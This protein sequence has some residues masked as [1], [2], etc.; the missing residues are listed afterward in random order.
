MN[1]EIVVSINW[2]GALDKELKSAGRSQA[3][4]AKIRK[5]N[6]IKDAGD[7]HSCIHYKR[8]GRTDAGVEARA[9]GWTTRLL[10]LP[11]LSMAGHKIIFW[12]YCRL[13]PFTF[14]AAI[15][16]CNPLFARTSATGAPAY[17]TTFGW[18][19]DISRRVSSGRFRTDAAFC[20][21]L[22]IYQT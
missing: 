17:T 2:R 21:K 14:P 19:G 5:W 10:N 7:G 15:P 20:D 9:D 1:E 3:T 6:W 12:I 16:D 22:F 18:H 4:A 13:P 11:H 8:N